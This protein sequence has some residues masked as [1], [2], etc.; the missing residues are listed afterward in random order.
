MHP[1]EVTGHLPKAFTSLRLS[2]SLP[3]SIW[4]IT[5][6]PDVSWPGWM[7]SMIISRLLLTWDDYVLPIGGGSS[8]VTK[9]VSAREHLPP[10]SWKIVW[11]A[12]I[13][14]SGSAPSGAPVEYLNPLNS[15]WSAVVDGNPGCGVPVCVAECITTVRSTIRACVSV[16]THVCS[17]LVGAVL[18][19]GRLGGGHRLQLF[20]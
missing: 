11:N 1:E 17:K 20:L 4:T 7:G 12:H 6:L 8:K 14:I 18:I 9:K 2:R 13:N 19:R 15:D 3:L 16:D 10:R 5:Y